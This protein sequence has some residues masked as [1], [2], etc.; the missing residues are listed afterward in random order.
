MNQ[1]FYYLN[2]LNFVN[3]AT[4]IHVASD[5]IREGISLK[6]AYENLG[7]IIPPIHDESSGM[8]SLIEDVECPKK[9]NNIILFCSMQLRS[10]M[11]AKERREARKLIEAQP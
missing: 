4:L 2:Q 7:A 1:I 3:T 11:E 8:I 9:L 5:A 6:K 10:K